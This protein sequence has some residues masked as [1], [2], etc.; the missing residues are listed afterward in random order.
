MVSFLDG[1][2][3]GCPNRGGEQMQTVNFRCGHCNNLMAVGLE[4]LGQQVRCPTCQNVVVAP[5]SALTPA[6]APPAPEPENLFP[7][8]AE[9][10]D[11]FSSST[12]ATDSLFDEP[13]H[14]LLELPASP[15]V[16]PEQPPDHTPAPE[17]MPVPALFLEPTIAQPPA[18][19][20]EPAHTGTYSPGT[21]MFPPSQASALADA[22]SAPWMSSPLD[23][24]QAAPA[25]PS[26]AEPKKPREPRQV[27]I[28]WFIPLV[29]LPLLLYAVLAT[30]AVAFLYLRMASAPPT[31]FD[32]LPDVQGDTP[33]TQPSKST[34]KIFNIDQKMATRPL[35]EHLKIA[36]G[37]TL[38]V[39]DLEVTPTKLERGHFGIFTEGSTDKALPSPNESLKLHLRLKNLAKDYSFT[40]LDNFFDRY[41]KPGSG[42]ATPLTLLQAGPETFF[43][44][45]AK[46]YSLYRDKNKGT[47]RDWLEG[48]KNVD[49]EGL[50]PGE[51]AETF[52][53]TDGWNPAIQLFLFGLD[54]EGESKQ[55]PYSGNLLW[56]VQLRRGLITYKGRELPAT[57][58]I[59]VEFTSADLPAKAILQDS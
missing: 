55:K 9:S 26:F 27:K 13:A 36:L 33:G 43:G 31:I 23:N 4:F 17:L 42:G 5:A 22:D 40:P 16:T 53:C 24:G 2:L 8:I 14:S 45:P 18:A 15:L 57:C 32:Q 11:I 35:P 39:G 46:W 50:A 37:S 38:V 44:G 48:R 30:V 20:E 21:E 12:Q 6:P 29:F 52:V 56:R 7:R 25:E 49:R 34:G 59:G 1:R 58:V 47:K 3:A 28:N 54:A 51:S 19:H 41:W 10:E